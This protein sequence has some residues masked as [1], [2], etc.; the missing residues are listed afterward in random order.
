MKWLV[1]GVSVGLLG[2]ALMFSAVT[3]SADR[4]VK[5]LGWGAQSGPLKSFGVNSEAALRSAVSEI[6]AGGGVNLGDGTYGTE[7][8][9]DTEAGR[10]RARA[11]ARWPR[12]PPPRAAVPATGRRT[13]CA[14]CSKHTE[15]TR[16]SIMPKILR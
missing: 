15:Q 8:V 12:G 9:D 2:Y 1:K 5:V 7:A 14:R 11:L 16:K 10:K 4:S 6:N 13:I 3:S